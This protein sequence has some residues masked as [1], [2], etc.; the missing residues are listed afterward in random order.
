MQLFTEEQ[1]NL[2]L[3]GLAVYDGLITLQM[4]ERLLQ[5][6]A[7]SGPEMNAVSKVRTAMCDAIQ[8]ATGI[9]YDAAMAE[10]QAKMAAMQRAAQQQ[11]PQAP[12][13]PAQGK[14]EASLANPVED[15]ETAGSDQ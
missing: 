13:E 12:G 14:G 9:N 3:E 5:T 2:S 11:I 1:Q 10:A 7:I 4:V 8:E 6:R 15:T